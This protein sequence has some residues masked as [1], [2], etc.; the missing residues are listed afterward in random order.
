MN[1][2]N[3]IFEI[4]TNLGFGWYWII[5]FFSFL[6][7]LVL[8]GE[9][10]PGT[11]LVVFVGFMSAQG[12]LNIGNLIW[13]VAISAIFGDGLSFYLGAKGTHFFRNE[14]KFLKLAHLEYGEK[15]FH[16][17]GGKSILLGRFIGPLR[18]IVPFIAG[19]SKMDKKKFLYWNI[20]SG[21]LWSIFYLFL[22]FFLGNMLSSF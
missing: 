1:F 22:G 7:S 14:N 8:I 18:S 2:F 13:I 6:E 4:L 11:T 20:L 16:K 5:L 10:V 12:F 21:F 17:Y 15:F 19:L 3:H 9:F